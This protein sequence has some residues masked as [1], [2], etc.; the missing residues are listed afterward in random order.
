M[1]QLVKNALERAHILQGCVLASDYIDEVI[2]ILR[3]SKTIAEAKSV[4][5]ERFKDVDMSALLDRSYDMTGLNLES[6]TGLSQEQADAIVQMKLGQLTGLERQKITDELYIL[7]Q[8][9]YL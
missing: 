8:N 6:Q 9:T 5:L 3:T 1:N 2:N 7:L 4:M